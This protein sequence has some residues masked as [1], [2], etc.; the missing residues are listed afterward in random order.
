[1]VS[2]RERAVAVPGARV[3]ASWI[4]AYGRGSYPSEQRYLVYSGESAPADWGPI[5]PGQGLVLARQDELGEEAQ[6]VPG[7]GGIEEV[8]P[9]AGPAGVVSGDG[10]RSLEGVPGAQEVDDLLALDAEEI[11]LLEDGA[12]HVALRLV[13]ALE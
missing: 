10:P 2:V 13:A 12:D 4:L 1:M 7:R 11:A 6:A 8:E 3:R 5:R 9:L